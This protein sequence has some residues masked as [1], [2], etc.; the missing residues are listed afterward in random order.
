MS[1]R[2]FPP[3]QGDERAVLTGWLDWQ[4]ATVHR[5]CTGLGD[6]A[7][8]Q[9]LI[10]GSTLSIA[11]VVSHLRWVESLWF[12]RNFLGLEPRT[13][14]GNGG[15]SAEELPLTHLLN[16][17]ADQCKR[18]REIVNEHGLDE[19]EAYAPEGLDH[20]SLRWIL[21]HLIEETARHLGHMDLLREAAD[22][23]RGYYLPAR[24]RL[25][26]EVGARGRRPRPPRAQVAILDRR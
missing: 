25:I 16:A 7:A 1:E 21:G 6:G 8:H 26:R 17:Y 20:V 10:P 15:W 23:V 22:G 12:E 9:R 4:R 11:S 14:D 24:L 5:K 3:A 18:S 2:Q 19:P 13:D